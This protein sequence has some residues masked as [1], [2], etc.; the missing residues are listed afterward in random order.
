MI[1]PGFLISIAT[2][3]GVIVH[4]AAHF[5]FCRRFGLAI[6]D[7]CW[8]RVGNPAGYVV[9][10]EPRDFRAAFFVSLGPFF[11][12]TFLCLLFCSAA[13]LP[14]HE[15]GVRDPLGYFFAWLGLSIGMHA[16]PSGQDLSNLRELAPAARREGSVLAILSYPVVWLLTLANL[17]RF[18]WLDYLYG[19]AVGFLLPL[20]IFRSLL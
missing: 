17:G 4:E 10:E 11:L 7:V 13:F 12:N 20:A 1:V 15:L 5:L 18:F 9:H 6:L 19:F 8:F 14:I 2:F 16:F 3:P